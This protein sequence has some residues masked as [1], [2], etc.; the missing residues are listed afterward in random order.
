MAFGSIIVVA[1][2]LTLGFTREIIEMLFHSDP[3]SDVPSFADAVAPPPAHRR[4]VICLAVLALYI[5]DFA[6][7]AVM[8]CNRSLLVDTL[9]LE[10]QQDGAAWASRMASFGHLVGYAA[11][12]IDLVRVFGP[13]FGDTQFKKLSIVASL[14]IL[15][16]CGITCWA[17][18]ERVLLK[19]AQHGLAGTADGPVARLSKIFRQIWSTLLTLP[20]RIQAICWAVFWGWIGWFPFIVY[21]STWVGETYFRYDAPEGAASSDVVGEMGRIGSY[22]LTAYSAVTVLASG[23]LPMLVRSPYN[24][25][26]T[27]RPPASL[28]PLVE[29]ID[30]LRPDLL[31]V[32]TCGHVMFAC[33]MLMAPFAHSFQF[34]TVLVTLCGIPWTVVT[35]A[36][37]ALLGVEVNKLTG[38]SSRRMSN[39]SVGGVPLPSMPGGGGMTRD[40]SK[41]EHGVHATHAAHATHTAHHGHRE[42]TVVSTGE[43]S[44]I[45]F[46][47]LNIY[48]TLP[49][50]LG[51]LMSAFIFAVLEPGKSP[52]LA[53]EAHPSE[54]HST[55]GPSA[56]AVTLFI[57]AIFA[58]MGAL[59]TRKLARL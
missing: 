55:D 4:L 16:T 2:L 56:I 20:P 50:L 10:K 46:G 53:R 43:L 27:R 44:G 37:T 36:P 12:A 18:T 40:L 9:P 47:I 39:A 3:E 28:A 29:L 14:S 13:A 5:T 58:L 35:W 38:G 7:N 45:Y 25:T 51:N 49:Q 8:S 11:G 54:H 31:T 52:E 33:S 24:D 21:S 19:S 32:W 1:G 22:A 34:A 42:P 59:A 48:T 26:F 17:V 15:M 30:K 41:L 6:I 57:G 23:I